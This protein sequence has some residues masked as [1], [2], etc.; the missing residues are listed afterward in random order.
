MTSLKYWLWLTTRTEL[1][2]DG[3]YR[4]LQYFGTPEA[5][6]FAPDE[7]YNRLPTLKPVAKASL[8]DKSMER[9]DKILADCDRLGVRICAI[10]DADYPERLR[11]IPQPP[12]VLYVRGKAIHFDDEVAIA[13]AG[14]RNCSDYGRRMAAK[15]AAE[16]AENGGLVVTGVVPGCDYAAATGALRVGGPVVCVLAGG[17]DIP[18]DGHSADL[19]RR[20]LENGALVSELPPGREPKGR[21]FP[22]RNRILTGLCVGTLCVEGSR[23]SGVMLVAKNALEQNRDV[24]VVPTGADRP[25]GA[26]ILDL[27]KEGAAPV[28]SGREVLEGY[29]TRYPQ[30]LHTLLGERAEKT[31]KL[32]AS[33]A[34]APK[35]RETP[36]QKCRCYNDTLQMRER[37]KE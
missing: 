20:V 34:S 2:L 14:T 24:F 11:Q 25:E 30:R 33:K 12:P 18:F 5:A 35:Q 7:E 22:Q 17:V 4:T 19:Y 10:Q 37:K 26:G 31:A 8:R 13:M 36:R 29:A 6:Y 15:L 16:I 32:P 23:T 9:P 27:L 3:M 1:S 28:T 21:N